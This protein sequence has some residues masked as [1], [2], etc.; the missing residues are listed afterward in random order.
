MF[1][2]KFEVRSKKCSCK[3]KKKENRST[4]KQLFELINRLK[5]CPLARTHAL[6]LGRHWSMA[7]SMTLCLNSAQPLR[8]CKVACRRYWGEVGGKF[9]H[10]LWLIYPR[11]CISLSIKIGQVL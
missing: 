3:N 4:D 10:T 9:Y 7:L 2:F 5:C 6:S 8:F 1:A 11:Q